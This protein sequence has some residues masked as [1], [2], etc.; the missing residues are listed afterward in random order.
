[1]IKKGDIVKIIVPFKGY[2]KYGI[3]KGSIGEVIRKTRKSEHK[4]I[5]IPYPAFQVEF[6]KAGKELT[7][8]LYEIK[9]LRKVI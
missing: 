4:F 9:K 1:M 3:R 7:M 6:E 5:S 8:P 2:G